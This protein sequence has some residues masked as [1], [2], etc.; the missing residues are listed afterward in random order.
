MAEKNAWGV[1]PG[2]LPDEATLQR[3]EDFMV[4]LGPRLDGTAALRS[5][6]D[7]LASELADAGLDVRR[8][9]IELD[10]WEHKSWSL[11][12]VDDSGETPVPVA[13]YYPYSG[14]TP[15]GGVTGP[16]VD[17]GAGLATD[18]LLGDFRGKIAFVQFDLPPLIAGMFFPSASYIYDPD[19][20]FT[21]LTDYKRAW[22]AILSP[23]ISIIDP[24]WSTT[25]RAASGA[26]A[27]GVIFSFDG[28]SENTRGQYLPFN[29]WPGNSPHV[30]ALH[31][32]RATGNRIKA[33]I[34]GGARARLELFIQEHVGSSTDDIIATL[35]GRSASEVIVVNSHTDG[36]SAA[37]ENGGLGVLALARYFASLPV[38]SRP[39]TMVF[40]LVPG[41]FYGGIH[42][43]T[44]RFVANHPEIIAKAVASLT[45]EHLGQSEWLDDPRGLRGTGRYELAILFGSATPIQRLMKDAV[46]AEDLRRTI[47]SRPILGT[48]F[49]VGAALHRVG[50]PNASYITGPNTLCSF[51]DNQHLGKFRVKRM[52]AEL[53]MF[54]RL[55]TALHTTPAGIL[56]GGCL[57]WWLRL[58]HGALGLILAML[59]ATKSRFMRARK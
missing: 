12:L 6:H 4:A 9:P 53:R 2:P 39:R 41:H 42:G 24:P 25:L 40:A 18:F 8:E 26:G 10:W 5:F 56:R 16:I 23:E 17:A 47:V 11:V 14:C 30:P 58:W 43:D 51:A 45:M 27:I 50:V 35:P 13:S 38:S 19:R 52:A 55:A 37:E 57:A 59:R 29:G 20:T 22:T 49:G 34:A 44:E 54:A 32:D 7:F 31:V 33:R 1:V 36:C 15:S 48:Y 21:A 46:V 3:W 28:S